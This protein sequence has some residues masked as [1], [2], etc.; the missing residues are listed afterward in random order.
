MLGF[1]IINDTVHIKKSFLIYKVCCFSS[2]ASEGL[3]LQTVFRQQ[4]N[5]EWQNIEF[6]QIVSNGVFR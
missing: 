2:V 5:P 4:C 6:D 1:V 3:L